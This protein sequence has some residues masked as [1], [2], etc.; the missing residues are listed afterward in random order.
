M[1]T[2]EFVDLLAG[3]AIRMTRAGFDRRAEADWLVE[4]L[5][6]PSILDDNDLA[7]ITAAVNIT[8]LRDVV[9]T[10]STRHHLAMWEDAV[11]RC[12]PVVGMRAV[13]AYTAWLSG[14]GAL[15]WIAIE[16]ADD[17]DP[18]YS[19]TRF[20]DTALRQAVNPMTFESPALADLPAFQ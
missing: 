1:P 13:L 11:R 16:L 2:P 14:N 9:T 8:E 17:V 15:A 4:R 19:F 7:R 5:M 12:G 6:Q 18:N 10:C 3:H 20:V